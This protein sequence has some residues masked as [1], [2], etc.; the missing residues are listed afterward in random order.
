M[1]PVQIKIS[2]QK[3][4]VAEIQDTPVVQEQRA[5]HSRFGDSFASNRSDQIDSKITKN[6]KHRLSNIS[7]ATADTT[8]VTR[9]A[10]RSKLGREGSKQEPK[11]HKE[12]YKKDS[13]ASQAS[14]AS[15]ESDEEPKEDEGVPGELNEKFSD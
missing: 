6:Q 1:C 12:K 14:Q 3:G 13:Q 15:L 11:F 10:E 7:Q 2:N 5:N 8:I 9:G 4:S